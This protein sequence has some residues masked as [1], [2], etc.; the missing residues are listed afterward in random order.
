MVLQNFNRQIELNGLIGILGRSGKGKSTIC[1]LIIKLYKYDGF[2]RIDNVDIQSINNNFL[3]HNIIYI[4]QNPKMFNRKIIDNILY[5]CNLKDDYCKKQ[6]TYIRRNFPIINE[7]FN[8]LD[9]DNTQSSFLGNNL[10]GGQKQV[11][12]IVNGLI[13]D[14]KIIMIDEPTNSLDTLL[15]KEVIRLILLYKQIKKLL[16]L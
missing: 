13:Q 16:S 11:L 1:K 7:I 5:G 14:A 12:N 3:R 8:K 10:S 9:I 2:I 15:K 4:D 6:L